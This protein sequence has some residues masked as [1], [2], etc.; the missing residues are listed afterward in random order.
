M[1]KILS[2]ETVLF[3]SIFKWIILSTIVGIIVGLSTTVFLK[4]LSL[5]TKLTSS[6]SYYFIFLPIGL[7]ISTMLVTHLASDTEGHGTEK[8]IEAIHKYSGKINS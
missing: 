7:M 4:L 1:K 3:L 5:G 8:V 2:E 6:Y